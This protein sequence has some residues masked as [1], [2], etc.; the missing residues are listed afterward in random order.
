MVS[1]R[2]MDHALV[3]R[4]TSG[5][6]NPEVPS[7]GKSLMG[8]TVG[9][10]SASKVGRNVIELLKPFKVDILVYDP[11]LS[12]WDAGRLGVKKA[13]LDDLFVKSDF[14]TLHAPSIPQTRHIIGEKQLKLLRDGAVLINTSRGSVIDHSA[15]LAEAQTGRIFVA[16]DVTDPEPLPPD[17]PF[18]KLNNVILT[19][20]VSGAGYYGYYM[21]GTTTLQAL[22]DYFAKKP[23][24]GAVDFSKYELIG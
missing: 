20:H 2:L 1:H 18:R 12:D 9:I 21:I 24:D 8:S 17:S 10:V 19:P 22:E 5:W 11:Y 15:L 6:R 23:V 16:L 4:N 14:V 13:D 7:N 3:I